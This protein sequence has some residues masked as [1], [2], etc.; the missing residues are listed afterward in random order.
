M[1][2]KNMDK[3]SIIMPAFNERSSIEKVVADWMKESE[4]LRIKAT[5]RICEDGS[6]DGTGRFLR[7]IRK[8]YGFILDQTT[9]RRGYAGAVI[10]GI[11]SVREG[12]V[13]CID[14]DGQCDPKDL[15]K[16]WQRRSKSAVLIGWRVNRADAVQRKLFSG[17]FHT[18]F[19]LL[20][21]TPIH[22][23][24]APY[25]LFEINTVRPH[26][27]YLNFLRE[28]FWWG[29]VGMC[30][31]KNIPISELPINHLIRENGSTNVYL[32]KKIPGIA[33]RNLLGL[34]KLKIN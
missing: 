28:G 6:T 8:K 25:V 17:L 16:F 22:D 23:P 12:Y 30:V 34:I 11:S 13:L 33:V 24:S 15:D 9:G 14:S 21:P 5:I 20:F 18:V 31:K 3:L 27:K 29:F 2:C 4:K 19:N 10:S 7:K 26:I 32:M 1:F